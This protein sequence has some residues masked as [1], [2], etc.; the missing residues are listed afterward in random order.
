[1]SL[2]ASSGSVDDGGSVTLDWSSE[3]VDTCTYEAPSNPVAGLRVDALLK[4]YHE[5]QE[6]FVVY[7][8]LNVGAEKLNEYASPDVTGVRIE[9][10]W[11]KDGPRAYLGAMVPEFPNFFMCYGPNSNNFGG[12]RGTRRWRGPNERR[13]TNRGAHRRTHRITH[14]RTRSS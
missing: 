13:R 14:R 5:L 12:V 3:G 9:E 2:S 7:D 10:V 4:F 11:A 6:P 8:S 1:M